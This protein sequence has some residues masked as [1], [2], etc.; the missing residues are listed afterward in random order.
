M[1]SRHTLYGQRVEP[2]SCILGQRGHYSPHLLDR[3]LTLWAPD[4]NEWYL[5]VF[6]LQLKPL[7]LFDDFH[8]SRQ[9]YLVW[10]IFYDFMILINL[11]S[12]FSYIRYKIVIIQGS[13]F[14]T[15]A[16]KSLHHFTKI[17]IVTKT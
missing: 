8:D 14:F 6:K 11:L 10:Y 15:I 17:F 1:S 13:K 5:L 4:G 3:R 2:G 9:Q 12:I 16:V 7:K